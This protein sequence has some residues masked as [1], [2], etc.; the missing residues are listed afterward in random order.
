MAGEK[1][2]AEQAGPSSAGQ[3]V[4][5]AALAVLHIGLRAGQAGSP[6]RW[7]RGWRCG[8][9]LLRT[10][11]V[12]HRETGQRRNKEQEFSHSRGLQKQMLLIAKASPASRSEVHFVH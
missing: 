3:I 7:R 10:C 8:R 9:S 5:M 12:C 4:A 1:R 6:R 11:G 2:I